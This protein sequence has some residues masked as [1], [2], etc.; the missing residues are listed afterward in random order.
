MKKILLALGVIALLCSC[1]KETVMSY[2][3]YIIDKNGVLF[4]DGRHYE[5]N[6][7]YYDITERELEDIIENYEDMGISCNCKGLIR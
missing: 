1:K 4:G 7:H 2:S 3:C 6:E 5:N